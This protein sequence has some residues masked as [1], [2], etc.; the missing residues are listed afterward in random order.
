M[1]GLSSVRTKVFLLF[2]GAAL[3]TVLPVL[4]L[5][6]RA[7][8]DQVYERATRDLLNANDALHLY[9]TNQDDALQE[10]A[11]RIAGTRS[12]P[13]LL[14]DGDTAGLRRLLSDQAEGRPFLAADSLGN[15]LVGPALDSATLHE[16]GSVVVLPEA[17]APPVRMAVWP[18]YSDSVVHAPGDTLGPAV[19]DSVRVGLVGVGRR[20]DAETIGALKN[21]TSRDVALIS[22]DSVVST[23]LP[24]SLARVLPHLDLAAKVTRN[25]TIWRPQIDGLPYL[26]SVSALPT[27]EKPTAIF[28]FRSVAE[29]L[30]IAR[31]IRRSVV[32]IGVGALVISLLLAL[33]VARIVARPAQALAAAATDLA[34]G[35]FGAPLPHA[36]DD[37]IG[38]LTRAF[39][40]M[41]SAIAEREAR[42]RSAQ[43]ELIHREKLAAMGRLVAQLSHEINNP[44]YNIQNCL[45]VLERRGSPD[46]PNREFLDLAR[47]ELDRMA[48]LTRQLL[49]QSRPL[50]DA[51]RP[52]N[53]NHLIQRVV[54]LAQSEL[55]A[56]GIESSLRLAS[57][58]P[59][60]VVHPDAI[61]QVLVN[62][63]DNAI[64]A[65]PGGGILR[66]HTRADDDAVEIAVEDTG[67]GIAPEHLPHIFEA[68][69]T[70]KPG[71]RG[72]GL[73]L[74]VS[75]GIVRGHRGRL[76]VESRPG[77]GSRFVIQLPRET[78][79]ASVAA[80]AVA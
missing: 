47:E 16:G 10:S 62:L 6:R 64:D 77:E 11:R 63:V 8:E 2:A 39:G 57:E 15:I 7:V 27:T 69:Y 53:L 43:A 59:P 1:R 17:G 22:G 41:R 74:F 45:E 50:A 21:A 66:V 4:G 33:L 23:T 30:K 76:V 26:Y 80:P 68:F 79:D 34:R 31:G 51:A 28:L 72:I 67:A 52:V 60:V 71:V 13:R 73:G 36:S 48:V 65:M 20:L 3:L 42:L 38:Q 40:E 75:E 58:L 37:E 5:V 12:L 14:A 25:G 19:A 49:D 29:E 70:T 55:D 32:A 54:T 18:V 35:H 61:R 46:D 24:D 56:R 9:W 44:I 78:L